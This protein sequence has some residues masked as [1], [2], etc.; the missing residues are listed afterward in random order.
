M[1]IRGLNVVVL[2][3]VTGDVMSSRWYDTYESKADSGFLV[4]HLKGLRRGRIICFAIKVFMI[5]VFLL[6]LL[7][8]L[9][10]QSRMKFK[11]ESLAAL[12]D[13]LTTPTAV[14]HTA[15][16]LLQLQKKCCC[17]ISFPEYASR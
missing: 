9:L 10:D 4:N 11:Q 12:Y 14:K 7:F 5:T 2:N 13:K 8:L 3:E 17:S 1:L 6:R 15:H 16:A